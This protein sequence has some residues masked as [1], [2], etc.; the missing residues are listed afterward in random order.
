MCHASRFG[1]GCIGSCQ[2]DEI[3]CRISWQSIMIT[4]LCSAA[5]CRLNGMTLVSW[6]ASGSIP[7]FTSALWLHGRTLKTPQSH[8]FDSLT[9]PSHYQQ[10]PV[11]ITQ[12]R[13][14]QMSLPALN[15]VRT[16][17]LAI[18]CLASS[19]YFQPSP[20][21]ISATPIPTHLQ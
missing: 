3:P 2:A 10:A 1:Q 12:S 14:P 11:T 16:P 4:D 21:L 19:A 5:V 9:N 13:F 20:P 17:S 18:R 15:L 8:P 6:S 7:L